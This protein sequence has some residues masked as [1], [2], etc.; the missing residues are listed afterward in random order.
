M[1]E[2][3]IENHDKQANYYRRFDKRLREREVMRFLGL[4]LATMRNQTQATFAKPGVDSRASLSSMLA[5]S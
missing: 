3:A 5:S 1:P 4:V 2:E